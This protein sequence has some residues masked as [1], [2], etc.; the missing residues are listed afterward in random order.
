MDFGTIKNKINDFKYQDYSNILDD[1]RLTFSNCAVYN[2][3]SSDIY[4]VGQRLS[5]YFENRVKQLNLV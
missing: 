1:I 3:P 4:K 2:E 5:N